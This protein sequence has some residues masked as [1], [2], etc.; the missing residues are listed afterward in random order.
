MADLWFTILSSSQDA[1]TRIEPKAA[2]RYLMGHWDYLEAH[3][4]GGFFPDSLN[5]FWEDDGLD[6]TMEVVADGFTRA[7]QY[8]RASHL[9]EEAMR[10]NPSRLSLKAKAQAAFFQY[11]EQLLREKDYSE[12]QRVYGKVLA[13]NPEHKRA[14]KRMEHLSEKAGKALS[15]SPGKEM[16]ESQPL[17]PEWK[18]ASWPLAFH[19]VKPLVKEVDGKNLSKVIDH[20][21]RRY[22]LD[23]PLI[24]AV[25]KAES[26][27]DPYAVSS[28]G[29]RGIMQLMPSTG[30]LMGVENLFDV[31]E[32]IAGGTQYLSHMLSLFK[33]DLHLALAAYNAG[34]KNVEKYGGIPPFSETRVYVKRVMQF[35]QTYRGKGVG[36]IALK[37]SLKSTPPKTY[38]PKGN[39]KDKAP[40]F[41]LLLKN[42]YTIRG[43]EVKREKGGIYLKM[44]FGWVMVEDSMVAKVF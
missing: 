37:P 30:M 14:L 8:K 28:E 44:K 2:I 39:L 21:A 27:Y 18:E 42:G 12:A 36:K 34:P 25:I 6:R 5:I 3:G 10:L 35:Y 11:G 22:G 15:P 41:I 32:N 33:G 20:F 23:P 13:L 1:R 29:A 17:I 7:N 38:L 4:Q 9:Y 24:Q 40:P 43:D 19:S 31:R 16:D 26:N